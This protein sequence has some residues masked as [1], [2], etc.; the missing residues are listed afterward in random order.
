MARL[1][2]SSP[3]IGALGC[4]SFLLIGWT[5]LLVPSLIRSVEHDFGQS[6]A[7]VGIFYFLYALAYAGGSLGGG[8]VTER[9]GRRWVLA[10]AACLHGI[11][12]AVLGTVPDWTVFLAAALPAGLGAGAIDGGINGLF[13]DLYRTS[14]GRALNTVHLFFSLGALASPLIVGRLVEAGIAW[15]VVVV[16]TAVGAFPVGALFALTDPPHGRHERP[17]T[18]RSAGAGLLALRWPLLALEIAIGCYV[19]SEV[20]VSS[21]LVR[22]LDAAPLTLATTS[23]SLFWGRLALGRLVSA[24]IADRFDHLAFATACISVASCALVAAVFV[25]SLPLSIALFAVVGFAFGPIFPVILAIAGELF[26]ARSAALGGLLTGAAVLGSILYPPVMGFL[27]V[28]V[29]L[30][31]AMLGTALLGFACA[32]SL[33]LTGRRR[34]QL[35]AIESGQ[36]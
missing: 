29:G 16:G 17:T 25:P 32:T 23:L 31:A 27:S 12:L 34:G 4:L 13:L 30:P 8:A 36:V 7:G 2:R 18:H 20:G 5:G 6:D 33:V 22:F 15:Q 11:G 21:W 26:P 10:L 1:V 28:T 19:A 24:R 35:E 9:L 14:R 3:V